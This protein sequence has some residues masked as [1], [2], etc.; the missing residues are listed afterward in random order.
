MFLITVMNESKQK[1][2]ELQTYDLCI[3]HFP[4]RVQ[5]Q[6][7]HHQMGRRSGSAVGWLFPCWWLL[8]LS[9]FL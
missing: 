3:S 7:A 2:G 9:M 6:K 1:S 5:E 4:D 8:S